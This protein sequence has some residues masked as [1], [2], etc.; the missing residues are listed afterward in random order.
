MKINLV[1]QGAL[2][3]VFIVFS[4]CG[5][6]N[7]HGKPNDQ[8]DPQVV[9]EELFEANRDFVQR[10]IE[11]INAYINRYGLQPK[12]SGTGLRYVISGDS[13]GRKARS[14]D[15]VKVAYDLKL[16][17]GKVCYRYPETSPEII[18]IDHAD[19]ISGIHEGLKLMHEGQDAVFIIPSH[20][21]F[22][23]TG[24]SNKVPPGSALVCNLKLIS[25]N[26]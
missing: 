2:A 8:V 6:M 3:C 14:G 5:G 18:E 10:E 9:Q 12:S 4:A 19:L 22:G 16:L 24:D 1:L 15:I 17:N 7:E 26:K 23:L 21:A 20:L 25:I 13:S 11:D